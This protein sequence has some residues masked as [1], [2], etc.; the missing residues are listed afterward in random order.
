VSNPLEER[1]LRFENYMSRY[2]LGIAENLAAHVAAGSGPLADSIYFIL[3]GITSYFESINQFV[4]GDDS[5]GKSKQFFREG[6]RLVFPATTLT[7]PELNQ[8]YKWLRC[9]MYHTAMPTTGATYLHPAFPQ[10]IDKDATGLKI[11]P[12]ELVKVIRAH[13]DRFMADLKNP[14]KAVERT[15]FNRRAE[16][17]ES[18]IPG[19]I[20]VS[21]APPKGLAP[22]LMSGGPIPPPWAPPGGSGGK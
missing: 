3:A 10:A 16:A 9:G 2:I 11:N 18:S 13:F 8:I 14:A 7:D 12:V 19:A 17:I 15:N 22:P 1:I 6:F 21:G 20:F 4:T 5:E